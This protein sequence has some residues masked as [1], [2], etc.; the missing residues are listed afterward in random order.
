MTRD[1]SLQ[2]QK[3]HVQGRIS[4]IRQRRATPVD[5][6]GDTADQVAHADSEAGPEE[7]EAGVVCLGVVQ[8][9][10]LDA[11]ELGGE[12]NGHDDAVDG[13]DL[14]ED[15]G[16]EVLGA[17]ARGADATADDRG[18]GDENTPIVKTWSERLSHG[19]GPEFRAGGSDVLVPCCSHNRQ[20]DAEGDAQAC[21]AYGRYGLEERADLEGYAVR[22]MWNSKKGAAVGGSTRHTLKASPLPVKSMSGRDG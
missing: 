7:G 20:A 11:G 3:S 18:A 14:A 8:L 5:A 21:P 15:D 22:S 10:A 9:G 17:D 19:A 2:Q 6:D 4:R 16:N 13:D 1:T 12:D